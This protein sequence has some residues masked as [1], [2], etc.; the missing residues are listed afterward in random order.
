MSFFFGEKKQNLNFIEKLNKRCI[1]FSISPY[2]K[3][4]KIFV[5][6]HII[7]RWWMIHILV[8][9]SGPLTK[10]LDG[11]YHVLD[12]RGWYHHTFIRYRRRSTGTSSYSYNTLHFFYLI[13]GSP[14]YKS[15]QH[16]KVKISLFLTWFLL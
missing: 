4:Y 1:H 9:W 11:Q 10:R 14:G 3:L 16:C 2:I 13:Y 7:E 5:L 8:E 6:F 15:L 12:V